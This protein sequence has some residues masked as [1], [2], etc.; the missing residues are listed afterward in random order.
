MIDNNTI[1]IV[2][3]DWQRYE[4]NYPA[5][6]WTTTVTWED[7]AWAPRISNNSVY[8]YL[9]GYSTRTNIYWGFGEAYHPYEEEQVLSFYYLNCDDA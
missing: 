2:T 8:N 5:Y 9:S 7:M 3:D 1:Y 4:R 6:T